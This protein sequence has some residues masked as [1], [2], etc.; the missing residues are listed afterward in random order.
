LTKL[1]SLP[2][3]HSPLS[4]R[5]CAV[6][7]LVSDQMSLEDVTGAAAAAGSDVPRTIVEWMHVF[8]TLPALTTEWVP[9]KPLWT[10]VAEYL[11]MLPR[12]GYFVWAVGCVLC[13][14]CLRN[15]ESEG[16]GGGGC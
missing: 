16:G 5:R 14:F 6:V 8:G 15:T 12:M 3:Q 13:V 9:V 10:I 2:I 1:P 7:C 11:M 4:V